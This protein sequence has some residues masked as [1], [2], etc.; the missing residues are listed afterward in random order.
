MRAADID[1]KFFFLLPS[2]F[3]AHN[4]REETLNLFFEVRARVYEKY[5][6]LA[7]CARRAGARLFPFLWESGELRR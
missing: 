6:L 1:C 4:I 2:L 3:F 5:N 7:D